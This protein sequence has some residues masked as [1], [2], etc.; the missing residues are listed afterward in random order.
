MTI[1]LSLQEE[2]QLKYLYNP[3]TDEFESLTP[4]LRDRFALGGRVNFDKGS[5]FPITDDVLEQIDN[6]IKNTNLNLKEIGK[7]IK[8][9]TETRGMTIDTPVMKKYIEKYA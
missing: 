1:Q 2:A 5:P 9:G 7:K 3:A 4:T 8:Y 6:L